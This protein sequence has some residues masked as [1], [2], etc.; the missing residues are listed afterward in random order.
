M[1]EEY[2]T[3][4]LEQGSR[5][6]RTHARAHTESKFHISIEILY[7]YFAGAAK[8]ENLMQLHTAPQ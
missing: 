1:K 6:A 5:T 3:G 2:H 7:V 4:C 8:R